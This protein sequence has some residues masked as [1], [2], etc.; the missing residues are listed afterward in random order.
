MTERIPALQCIG[1]GRLEAPQPCMGVCEDRE[2][3]VVS[4]IDYDTLLQAYRALR[5]RQQ[6]QQN[7][8]Q[9]LAWTRPREGQ[10]ETSWKSLQAQART[11]LRNRA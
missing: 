6:R 2:V 11:L 5:A 8:L 10:W 3:E 4:A 1:C 7:V 9:Q